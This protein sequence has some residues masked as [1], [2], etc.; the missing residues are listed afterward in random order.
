MKIILFSLFLLASTSTSTNQT[1]KRDFNTLPYVEP[2]EKNYYEVTA[3][4]TAYNTVAWQTDSTPCISANGSNICGRSDTVACPRAIPFGT[5]VSINGHRYE[6]VDRTASKY[7]G[8]FDISFDK[9]VDGA[10]AFGKQK[11]VVKIYN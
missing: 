10:R 2:T 6:C 11:L 3:T 7:D 8:R 4:V 1:I 9:D 5:W